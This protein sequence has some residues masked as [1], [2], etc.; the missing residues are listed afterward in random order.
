MEER[1]QVLE[2][3]RVR[4]GQSAARHRDQRDVVLYGQRHNGVTAR[5]SQQLEDL[6]KIRGDT[7]LDNIEV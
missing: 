5:A 1:R 4:K 3:T 6:Y 7:T 2:V